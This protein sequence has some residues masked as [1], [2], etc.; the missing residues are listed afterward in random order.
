MLVCEGSRLAIPGRMHV[1]MYPQVR[2]I[3]GDQGRIKRTADQADAATEDDGIVLDQTDGHSDPDCFRAY[4]FGKRRR[5]D[6]VGSI[7]VPSRHVASLIVFAE[8]FDLGVPLLIVQSGSVERRLVR[9]RRSLCALKRF[10]SSSSAAI[11]S[12]RRA[13]LDFGA[14]AARSF[15]RAFSTESLGV[16]AMADLIS[17]R[18]AFRQEEPRS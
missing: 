16:S 18:Q 11:S 15:S 12:V 10:I 9:S 1:S 13:F 3:F 6:L 5:A 4:D 2:L 17:R 8:R 7:S 14:S